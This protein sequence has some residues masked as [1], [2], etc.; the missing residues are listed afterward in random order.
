MQKKDS[1]FYCS[2]KKKASKR[3]QIWV[4][5][6][7]INKMYVTNP[8]GP[9]LMW[10]TERMNYFSFLQICLKVRVPS[11]KQVLG[12]G[13][14]RHMTGEKTKFISLASN[15]KGIVTFGDNQTCDIIEKGKIGNTKIAINNVHLVKSLK[16]N[17]I[18][19]S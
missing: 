12:N 11:S 1:R 19:I 6:G 16:Y 3:K 5:K 15:K 9:K 13:C 10:V 18:N 17:L 4:K 8:S 2:K 7:N 14:S